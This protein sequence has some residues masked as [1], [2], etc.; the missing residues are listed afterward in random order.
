MNNLTGFACGGGILGTNGFILKTTNGGL[1][2]I[3]NFSN[4]FPSVYK[5]YEN[6]PNPFNPSTKIKFDIPKSSLVKL[7]VYDVLGKEI[8]VLL[9]RQLSPGTYEA[10]WDGSNY[11]SGIYYYRLT[12]GDY[13][14]AKKM[15]LLK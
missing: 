4:K 10:E 15:I 9:D 3:N 11:T 7:A 1:T 14:E 13:S 5:F 2:F 8:A 6:Y 12:A